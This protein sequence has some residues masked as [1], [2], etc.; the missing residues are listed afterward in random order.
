M[1]LNRGEGGVRCQG[2][3]GAGLAMSPHITLTVHHM[4]ITVNQTETDSCDNG[5]PRLM[6]GQCSYQQYEDQEYLILRY[7]KSG[8]GHP[9]YYSEG[10]CNI[11][12]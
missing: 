8:K 11:Y 5:P 6:T 2:M 1:L 3:C 4:G 10:L 9:Q 12:I 7:L